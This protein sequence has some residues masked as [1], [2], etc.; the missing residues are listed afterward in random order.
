M[1][2][3]ALNWPINRKLVENLAE[4]AGK[5]EKLVKSSQIGERKREK[6]DEIAEKLEEIAENLVKSVGKLEK[7]VKLS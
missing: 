4:S 7:W 6:L 3:D 5:L 2:C 1:K